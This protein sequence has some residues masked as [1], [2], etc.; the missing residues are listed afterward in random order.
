MSTT[1]NNPESVY[2]SS[3]T[4]YNMQR[5][6]FENENVKNFNSNWWIVNQDNTIT[7]SFNCG[8]DAINN[9]T[10][11]GEDFTFTTRFYGATPQVIQANKAKAVMNDYNPVMKLVEGTPSK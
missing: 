5:F 8:D 11:N 1:F 10:T 2:F 3:I 9:I 6:L 4:V 7:I